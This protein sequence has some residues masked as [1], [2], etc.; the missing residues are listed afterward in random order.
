MVGVHESAGYSCSPH[1]RSGGPGS[2][3]ERVWPRVT[4]SRCRSSAMRAALWPER[5]LHLPAAWASTLHR[6]LDR[7]LAL[8][9]LLRLVPNLVVLVTGHA[10]PVLAAPASGF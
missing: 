7:A 3:C 1:N 4:D 9:D 2:L 6:A 5:L 10:F 8:A